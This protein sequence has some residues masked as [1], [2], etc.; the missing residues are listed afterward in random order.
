MEITRQLYQLQE[1]DTEIEH[2][3]Q[4]L[5]QKT[6]RL[7][8]REAPDAAREKLAAAQKYADGL[9]RQRRDAEGQV[10]DILSKIKAAEQQ[11][12]GGKITNPKELANLQHEINLLKAHNDDLETKALKIIELGEEAEKSAAAAGSESK[13]AEEE[14]QREQ[15]QLAGEIEQLQ[16]ALAGLKQEREQLAAQIDAPSLALYGKIRQQKKPAVAKVEQGI[17]RTCRISLSASALQR[18]RSGRPVQCGS[19]GRILYIS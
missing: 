10:D 18:A 4:S 19:C 3:A 1:L 14:W 2:A 7:G 12:Y 15:K 17:C 8:N 6:G 9:K 16:A 11:L 5:A 13:K